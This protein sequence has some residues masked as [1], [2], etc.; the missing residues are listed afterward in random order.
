[1]SITT[2]VGRTFTGKL[3]RTVQPY[4]NISFNY[5]LPEYNKK[6]VAQRISIK[7]DS[8]Y[9][10]T[11]TINSQKQLA[12]LDIFKFVNVNYDTAAQ[13]GK[14]VANLFMS[15]LDKYSWSNEAGVT[16]T[17]GFPGPYIST[18]LKKRNLFGGLEILELNGRFGF[19][20]V[21]S[22][23]EVG[24]FYQSTEASANAA[25]SFPQFLFPLS[26]AASF[27]YAKYNPRTRLS[28]GYTYTDRPEYQRKITTVSAAFSWDIHQK[29][30]FTFTPT[31]LNIIRST[32][33]STFNSIL[34]DL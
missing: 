5:F 24:N 27:R 19:E 17:Q 32:V 9:S 22:A 12:N 13:K 23:T 15:A 30:Q 20:G 2:D 21:A 25:I 28:A 34:E 4:E 7:R 29:F 18:S 14:M 8:L 3:K 31:N 11:N 33:D 16:V 1:V 10:R 6:I 26:R